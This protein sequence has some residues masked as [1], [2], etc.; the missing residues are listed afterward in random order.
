[1]ISIL[2]CLKKTGTRT[3][4]N[5]GWSF[6]PFPLM[7]GGVSTQLQQKGTHMVWLLVTIS[8]TD[9]F[10]KFTT[11]IRSEGIKCDDFAELLLGTGMVWPRSW[12]QAYDFTWIMFT[13]VSHLVSIYIRFS[14]R[15]RQLSFF[16]DQ[17]LNL[18]CCRPPKWRTS[19]SP[20]LSGRTLVVYHLKRD[21]KVISGIRLEQTDTLCMLSLFSLGWPLAELSSKLLVVYLFDVYSQW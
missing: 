6:S 15:S 19:S 16:T 13:S 14:V 1:M 11:D 20:V 10:W 7:V 12:G 17:S 18:R 3:H 2:L 4:P 8:Q 21:C 5:A 9:N